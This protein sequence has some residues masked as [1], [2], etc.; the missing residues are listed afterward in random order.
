MM[1]KWRKRRS[2]GFQRDLRSFCEIG[3][4]S[5]RDETATSTLHASLA[6]SK[7]RT[8][9]AGTGTSANASLSSLMMALPTYIRIK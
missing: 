4:L 3:P 6:K 5:S 7:S 9:I 2:R 8:S 1:I